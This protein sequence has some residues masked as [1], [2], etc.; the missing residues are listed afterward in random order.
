MSGYELNKMNITRRKEHYLPLQLLDA[1]PNVAHD[2][3]K[4]NCDTGHV[5]DIK[6][7]CHG[8]NDEQ[9][10]LHLVQTAVPW[11]LWLVY[12]VSHDC[13]NVMDEAG[14]Y[15]CWRCACWFAVIV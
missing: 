11:Q 3:R 4:N 15:V 7:L 5:D 13:L 2:V 9:E 14:V 8:H 6:H 12:T 1:E 10:S